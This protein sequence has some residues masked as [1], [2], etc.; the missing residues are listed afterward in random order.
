MPSRELQTLLTV[1]RARPRRGGPAA[2]IERVRAD[3]EAFQAA[4]RAPTDF[5]TEPVSAGGVP[6]EWIVPHGHRPERTVLFFHGGGYA[7]GSLG[8]HRAL[9]ARIARATPARVL[10]VGYRL[11]PEDPFPAAFEDARAV[12]RWLLDTGI[13]PATLAVGGDSAGGGLSLALLCAA[14]DAGE[15]LPAAWFGLSPWTDL[16]HTGDSIVTRAEQDPLFTPE[17]LEGMAALYAGDHPRTHPAISPLFA[18]LHDLPPGLLQ[19][20]TAELLLDDSTRLARRL[21]AA[22]VTVEFDVWESMFHGWQLFASM[23]PEG[24]QALEQVAAFVR[25]RTAVAAEV[26]P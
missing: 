10:Q 2:P 14:R 23:L 7:S 26:S 15:P 19:V 6:A 16:G 22:G 1:F 17:S 11:A 21:E 3:F 24:Q 13:E 25:R 8:T 18:D 20:G 5:T 12:Y 4:L 9:V